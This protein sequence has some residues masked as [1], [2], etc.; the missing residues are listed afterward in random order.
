MDEYQYM[1]KLNNLTGEALAKF[2]RALAEREIAMNAWSKGPGK[3]VEDVRAA[4]K[5][6]KAAKDEKAVAELQA[7]Y[8]LLNQMDID[9]RTMLRSDVMSEL[10]IEQQRRW[11]GFVINAQVLKK[12]SRIELSDRQKE[13]IQVLAD[14]AADRLVKQETVEKD[15]FLNTFKAAEVIDP[16]VKQARDKVLTIE[17]RARVPEKGKNGA[18]MLVR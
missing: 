12:L 6:A 14:E 2:D 13:R 17:Q 4:M 9:Y 16:I 10:N 18:V 15:P 5:A 11:A 8:D 1:A 3:Q 7:K